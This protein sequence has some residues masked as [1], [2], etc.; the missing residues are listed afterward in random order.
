M[1]PFLLLA[2]RPED[3]AAEGEA[4]ALRHLG[5]LQEHELHRIRLEQAPMP[6]LDLTDYAGVILGGG[7]FNSS[8]EVKSDLQLRIEA[9]LDKAL[10]QVFAQQVPFL[11]L[12]YGIGTVTTH[13]GGRV[14]RS[15]GEPVGAIEVTVTA[16]GR[17]DPLLA[18]VGERFRAFVGHKEAVAELPDG[19]VLLATGQACPVQMYRV[20]DHCWVTQFHPELDVAGLKQRIHIYRNAGYFAPQ[21]VDRLCAAADR[22]D[23]DP[24]VH[25]IVHRFVTLHR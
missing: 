18:E 11:G 10:Q 3:E 16:E 21:E 25:S 7:P 1:K 14:D 19:A 2:T 4:A 22:A 13:L 17:S 9:D 6:A 15:H 8:D 12:C 24:V 20:R 5:G 23:L